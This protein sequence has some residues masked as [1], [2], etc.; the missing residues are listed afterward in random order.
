MLLFFLSHCPKDQAVSLVH[1]AQNETSNV[2]HLEM[3]IYITYLCLSGN[4]VDVRCSSE[5]LQ[6][7]T[8]WVDYMDA[9]FFL[10]F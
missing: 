4:F 6:V 2:D 9:F 5:V 3:P 10:F 7:I 1:F 8:I